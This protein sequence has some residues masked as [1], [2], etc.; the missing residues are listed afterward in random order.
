MIATRLYEGALRQTAFASWPGTIPAG[1]I[2]DS[3]WARWDLLPT[4]F[5]MSGSTL[6]GGY[7]TGGHSLLSYI[8]A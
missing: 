3:P 5:E 4:F 8:K 6:P 1:R 2:D 7:V